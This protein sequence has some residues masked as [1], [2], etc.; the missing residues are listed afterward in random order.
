MRSKSSELQPRG[1]RLAGWCLA[2]GAP[3]AAATAARRP[4]S[5]EERLHGRFEVWLALSS[6]TGRLPGVAGSSCPVLRWREEHPRERPCSPLSICLFAFQMVSRDLPIRTSISRS[7]L[8]KHPMALPDARPD[9]PCVGLKP[10]LMEAAPREGPL[11]LL[12]S[13]GPS[14]ERSFGSTGIPLGS[15]F[16]GT[17]DFGRPT[18]PAADFGLSIGRSIALSFLQCK[19]PSVLQDVDYRPT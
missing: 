4:S 16:S 13:A 8:S 9:A 5:F 2:E 17:A 18:T 10:K 6:W 14:S 3:T 19:D 11:R 7:P 15:K 1:W 12:L